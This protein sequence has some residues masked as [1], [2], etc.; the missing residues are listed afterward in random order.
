MA[1]VRAPVSIL[2][3]TRCR[4]QSGKS[5]FSVQPTVIGPESLP[6]ICDA[7]LPATGK[8]TSV[9]DWAS[10]PQPP[11]DLAELPVEQCRQRQRQDAAG[12]PENFGV[13]LPIP[14][15]GRLR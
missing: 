13:I 2:A 3:R 9:T 7:S 5:I 6:P 15:L 1:L 11:Q 14:R 4:P 12:N 8:S 10:A